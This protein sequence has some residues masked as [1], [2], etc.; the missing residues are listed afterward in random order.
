MTHR[1]V[2]GHLPAFF[3][4]MQAEGLQPLVID[5][6]AYYYNQVVAG[7]TGLVFEHEIQPPGPHE[8]ENFNNLKK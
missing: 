7:E 4:K 6:F 3:A 8:I 5:T 2:K 1:E